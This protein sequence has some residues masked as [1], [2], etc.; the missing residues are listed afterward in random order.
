[1]HPSPF[2]IGLA[3]LLAAAFIGPAAQAAEEAAPNAC[4]SLSNSFGP[5]DYRTASSV[6]KHLVESY[7]YGAQVD[8]LIAG[9][10]GE[11]GGDISY[12]LVVFP[13]HHR[14][15]V[16]MMRMGERQKRPQVSGA[17]YSVE[18]YFE[19]ALRFRPD[20]TVARM[21]YAQYLIGSNRLPDARA[22]L[23]ETARLGAD[24]PYTQYNLG[25]I[26]FDLKDYD[27]AL[28]QAHLAM[29]MGFAPPGLE[30]KLRGAGRWKDPVPGAATP[31]ASAASAAALAEDAMPSAQAASA[32]R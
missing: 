1:M 22:Q 16:A 9:M 25:M 21:I 20:D 31:A 23:E 26:Y 10:T 24:N 8:A 17:K 12:T 4:G 32:A 5:F 19:R 29:S 3:A 27:R 14:A 6:D 7:H 28:K 11:I 2:R 30:Q 15:L 18:C 13:N